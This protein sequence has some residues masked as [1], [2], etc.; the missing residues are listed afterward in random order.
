V[1]LFAL[2]LLPIMDIYIDALPVVHSIGMLMHQLDFVLPLLPVLEIL[3]VTQLVKCVFQHALII[4]MLTNGQ[5]LRFALNFVP[6]A[7]TQMIQQHHVLL[8]ALLLT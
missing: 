2:L 3:G 6:K 4:T 8:C 7:T 5:V 1:L